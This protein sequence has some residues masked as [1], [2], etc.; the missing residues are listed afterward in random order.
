MALTFVLC[1]VIG[2]LI[3]TISTGYIYGKTQ[4][5]DIRDYGSGNAGTTNAFRVL[6]RK[7]GVVTFI[8][9]FLKAFIPLILI[10]YVFFKD[11]D[12]RNLLMLVFGLGVVLGHNYPV[13]L[14]FKGGKGIASTGGVF[15]AFDPLIF[16]PGALCFGGLIGITK[17]V[18]VGSIC[19]SF[20]F[21]VWVALR[22]RA[23]AYYPW[24]IA[25]TC[26]YTLSALFRHRANIMR[27][28]NGTENKIGVR[29]DTSKKNTEQ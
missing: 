12:Y 22:F 11:A 25:V 3:G 26:L 6:G 7:G 17:Y 20:L 23:D 13:W 4:K 10:K 5:L 18:S 14:H 15:V 29:A 28:L 9:D 24:L 1:I 16:I 2:Y 27:L 19:L 21:P 8:G